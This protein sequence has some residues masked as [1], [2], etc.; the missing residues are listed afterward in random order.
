[1]KKYKE[2]YNDNYN[3]LIGITKEDNF[4]LKVI[5]LDH[6]NNSYY[7]KILNKNDVS[8]IINYSLPDK[9]I[10]EIYE[11]ILSLFDNKK[12]SISLSKSNN[13][14]SITIT[15]DKKSDVKLNKTMI[16]D[17]VEYSN[18]L[19][20][21]LKKIKNELNLIKHSQSSYQHQNSSDLIYLKEENKNLQNELKELAGENISIK[22]EIAYLKNIIQEKITNLSPIID[23]SNIRNKYIINNS[24]IPVINDKKDTKEIKLYMKKPKLF[25]I[26]EFNKLFKIAIINNDITE[27]KLGYKNLGDNKLKN[28]TNINFDNLEKLWLSYNRISDIKFL[29]ELKYPKLQTL[30]LSN[31]KIENINIFENTHFFNLRKLWLNNNLIKDISVFIK[32][33]CELLEELNLKNNYI[34]NISSL[35]KIG[36][37][38]L[39]CLDLAGNKIDIEITK[40]K[41][42]CNNMKV[43]IKYFNI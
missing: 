21:F 19:F 31:N 16:T 35:E 43:R 17:L 32:I 41:D 28:L 20:I 18:Y 12:F 15:L 40:N 23:D 27:L 29:E 5:N 33:K 11:L 36:L 3:I 37:Y 34:S 9:K 8:E 42:I 7:I 39:K 1:M 14:E 22:K 10:E 4:L 6:I 24:N 13:D 2:Y 25:S 38:H 30:D 26:N